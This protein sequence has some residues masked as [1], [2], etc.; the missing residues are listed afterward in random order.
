MATVIKQSALFR[1]HAAK[2]LVKGSAVEKA[3]VDFI[4]TKLG[5]PIAPY[6]S[7][8]KANPI[9]TPMAMEV[10]KIRH[11]HL[12]HNISIFYTVSGNPTVIRLY[13]MMSHDEAGIGQPVNK[14]RQTGVAKQFSRQ[15][16]AQ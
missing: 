9:G 8:D 4:A 12:S 15:E 5:N 16:F 7:T 10:P 3:F 11:A 6:G 1:E 2:Y 14:K 13:G